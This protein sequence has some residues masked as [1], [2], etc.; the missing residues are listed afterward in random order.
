MY[1]LFVVEVYLT[2]IKLYMHEFMSDLLNIIHHICHDKMTELMSIE[3][4]LMP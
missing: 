4:L 3:N 2:Q 1:E